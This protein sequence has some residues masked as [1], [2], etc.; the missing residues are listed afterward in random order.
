M[1]TSVV[2]FSVLTSINPVASA[3]PGTFICCDTNFLPHRDVPSVW[4]SHFSDSRSVSAMWILPM[5]WPWSAKCSAD[6]MLG[7]R[8]SGTTAFKTCL[9][10]VWMTDPQHPGG[11]SFSPTNCMTHTIASFLKW[12]RS[13]FKWRTGTSSLNS[14]LWIWA[15]GCWLRSWTAWFKRQI[16]TSFV[17]RVFSILFLKLEYSVWTALIFLR[18]ALAVCVQYPVWCALIMASFDFRQCSFLCTLL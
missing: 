14:M 8:D 3:L 16:S 6:L 5:T 2:V 4:R 11:T 7:R 12:P 9:A 17:S 1:S 15:A 13:S 10:T 18:K